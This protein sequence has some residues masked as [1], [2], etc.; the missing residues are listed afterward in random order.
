MMVWILMCLM[1]RKI[2]LLDELGWVFK[3]TWARDRM[4]FAVQLFCHIYNSL[5]HILY[6][7]IQLIQKKTIFLYFL[8]S[9]IEK[10][11]NLS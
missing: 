10:I 6:S 5:Q 2:L 3:C 11:S 4:F 1:I 7:F 9:D 8:F